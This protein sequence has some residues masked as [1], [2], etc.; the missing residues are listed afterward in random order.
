MLDSEARKRLDELGTERGYPEAEMQDIARKV[1]L[2]T[3]KY[4]DLKNNR[5]ADYVFDIERFAQFEGNTGPYLLYASVRIKSILRKAAE[6]GFKPGPLVAPNTPFER[7]LMLEA[8]KL[9]DFV[10]RAAEFSEPHHLADYGFNLSQTFNTFYK[11]C[12]ILR[13]EDA[14]RRASWLTLCRL[15]HDQL[16]LCL[17]LLG[18]EIPERM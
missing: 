9:P 4:A 8:L 10:A 12:H 14:A 13:E 1:G 6:L 17:G 16:A 11:E 5:M 2:A 3:L 18:I 7:A 15:A